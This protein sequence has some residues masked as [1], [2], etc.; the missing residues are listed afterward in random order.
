ME[1]EAPFA[2][3]YKIERVDL[4][5]RGCD[6]ECGTEYGAFLD[7]LRIETGKISYVLGV[8]SPKPGLKVRSGLYATPHP[9]R[10]CI[11]A[12]GTPF[13]GDTRVPS[14]F[15]E[16]HEAHGN[17]VS[18]LPLTRASVLLLVTEG[19]IIAIDEG[20]VRWCSPRVA[21]DSVRV[22]GHD[23]SRVWGVADA[24][25]NPTPFTIDLAAGTCEGGSG[26]LGDS[27]RE[28]S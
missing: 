22:D 14:S 26:M 23:A 11:V 9:W 27:A 5:P 24:D 20:G 6:V 19:E 10:A 15:Q 13:L 4:P 16:V 3:S 2:S 21:V 25:W 7:S 8:H 12:R 28:S 18:V 1:L 17:V